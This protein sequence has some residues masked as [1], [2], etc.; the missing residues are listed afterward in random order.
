MTIANELIAVL[1]TAKA[2][3]IDVQITE[4][5]NGDIG[6]TCTAGGYDYFTV[7]SLEQLVRRIKM[8][9]EDWAII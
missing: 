9:V 2:N 3:M 6:C 1:N 4:L 5:S 8:V 7:S